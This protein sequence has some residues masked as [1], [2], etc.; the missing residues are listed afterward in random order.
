MQRHH[1]AAND[2][3]SQ[4]ATSDTDAY[5]TIRRIN[6]FTSDSAVEPDDAQL[7][8]NGLYATSPAG[9]EHIRESGDY[10]VP[11]DPSN[12]FYSKTNH[13]V[14]N[15]EDADQFHSRTLIASISVTNNEVDTFYDNESEYCS[16]Y[17]YPAS[18]IPSLQDSDSLRQE[19]LPATSQTAVHNDG[20]TT[21]TTDWVAIPMTDNSA[22]DV[23]SARNS[24][25]DLKQ[26]LS[27]DASPM[28]STLQLIVTTTRQNSEEREGEN[29]LST[30]YNST[31]RLMSPVKNPI[32]QSYSDI[33]VT[34][35]QLSDV[36]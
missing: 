22:Y 28:G 27:I 1:E 32:Y 18:V 9:K 24:S 35:D 11:G 7:V 25:A 4:S 12:S 5:D 17:N 29:E 31:D 36:S 30:S 23:G 14:H 20:A 34:D 10:S 3:Q 2:K 15:A 21:D 13:G 26:Q 19:T 16:I 6:S 33:A 8:Y